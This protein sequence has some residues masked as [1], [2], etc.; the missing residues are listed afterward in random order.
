MART[1]NV[2]KQSNSYLFL[3]TQGLFVIAFQFLGI[4]SVYLLIA[5]ALGILFLVKDYRSLDDHQRTDLGLMV[6]SLTIF[7]L[8]LSIS[9]LYLESGSWLRNGLLSL[10]FTATYFLGFLLVKK[11]HITFEVIIK[12]LLL[13]LSLFVLINVLYTLYRYLP[14][15]R[16]IFAGQVIYVNGEVYV[17]SEEVK[18][19]I[20]LQFK[21]V[22]VS[23]MSFYLT[24][25][26]T[27]WLS[28]IHTLKT[29]RLNDWRRHGWWLLPTLVGLL[30]VVFLPVFM[31]LIISLTLAI[32]IWSFPRWM[33]L[34]KTYPRLFQSITYGV[35]ALIA[36]MVVLFFIDAYNVLGLGTLIKQWSPLQR[37]LDFPIL[38]GYQS[39]LRSVINY[40]FGGF[41]PIIVQGR[42]LT[43]TS[44]FFFDTLHQGGIFALFGLVMI[45]V[46]FTNQ[47][48]HF[49]RQQSVNLSMRMTLIALVVMFMVYQTFQTNLYPFVREDLRLIPRLMLDEPLWM[50]MFFLMG[51]IMID[52]FTGIIKLK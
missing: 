46:F 50:M 24:L 7:T 23:Y 31:P 9:P 45:G 39:V 1:G 32:L 11:Y 25:L 4:P 27:P 29:F 18:W 5:L 52:P 19:L 30:G 13:G 47:L 36:L 40:P 26:L 35:L 20:G 44:S 21:E 37:I 14:F 42:Y 49:S 12:T 38:E 51:T 8:F 16:W 33:K 15:Y 34:T 22:N 6:T 17:V 3:L 48:I 41:A 43:T 10:G 2:I 28:Q